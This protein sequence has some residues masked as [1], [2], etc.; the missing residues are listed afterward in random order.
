VFY[1][2]VATCGFDK[3]ERSYARLCEAMARARRAGLISFDVIRD[4]GASR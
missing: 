4:D 1:R 3:T 2:L